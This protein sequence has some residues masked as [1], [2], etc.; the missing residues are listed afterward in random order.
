[1]Y[2]TQSL[3]TSDLRLKCPTKNSKVSEWENSIME[4]QKN[5]RAAATKEK[6]YN[7][8]TY[9]LTH[10]KFGEIFVK[11]ICTVACIHRSSFYE[12]Y[13]DINDLMIKTEKALSDG[14]AEI[15]KGAH[16][17]DR[18]CFTEL[19]EFIGKHSAFYGAYLNNEEERIMGRTDF[20]KFVET[21]KTSKRTSDLEFHMAF[22]A[23]GLQ[24][25][26]KAWILSGMKKT[27]EQMA[28]VIFD[29]YKAKAEYF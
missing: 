24:A 26:C 12:H 14:I 5:S 27:P 16:N 22:F 25:V 2:P 15:F 18:K 11:D 23:G 28:D 17:F 9:L 4:R 29:E 10:K 13:Q 20:I 7:A 1:M 21:A 6:I 8:L 19:F 3:K